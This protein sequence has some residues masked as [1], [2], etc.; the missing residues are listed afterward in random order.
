MNAATPA[1]WRNR[2]DASQ[3]FFSVF[4]FTISHESQIRNHIDPENQ[5]HDSAKAPI[6]AYHPDTPEVRKDWTQYYDRLTMMDAQCGEI[7]KQLQ[8]DSLADDT[9]IFYWGDHGSGMPRSKRWPGNSGLHVPLIVHFPAKWQHLAPANYQENGTNSERV[10]FVDLAPTMLSIAGVLPV[11]CMQGKPFAG[12]YQTHDFPYS[13]GMRNRMDS[14]GDLIRSVMDDRYVYLRN[15]TPHRMPG[16]FIAYMFET[17]TT[18]V[19]H[20]RYQQGSLNNVQSAFWQSKPTEELYDL[21]NDPDETQNLALDPAH[22]ATLQRMRD[23]HIRWEYEIRDLSFMP[24]AIMEK[25]SQGSTPY[26]LAHDPKQY[27][28]PAIFAAA[29]V[30]SSQKP[31]DLPA[32]VEFLKSENPSIRYWGAVG[33]LSHGVK[34]YESAKVLL[35]SAINDEVKSVAIA[36]A[37][38]LGKYGSIEEKHAAVK[39]LIQSCDSVNGNFYDAMQACVSLDEV[40]EAALPYLDDIRSIPYDAPKGGTPH[41]CKHPK[42]FG[43]NHRRSRSIPIPEFKLNE[44][45]SNSV[46]YSHEHLQLHACRIGGQTR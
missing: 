27:D 18:R 34:G 41:G 13:Y 5:I 11:D 37:E 33:L 35:Q 26:D 21:L 25:L 6:P 12:D 24:E 30:A 44:T 15:Y 32:I 22:A 45:T 14:R 23:A 17:P 2:S 8:E 39:L 28:F 19:W 4:N 42:Y 16:Q 10:A 31:D 36:A 20:D 3:P 38:V 40:D 9:I 46:I 7:L 43:K 1:H 29:Q